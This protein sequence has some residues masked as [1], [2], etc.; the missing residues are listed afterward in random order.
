[1][2]TRYVECRRSLRRR[3]SAFLGKELEIAAYF[4]FRVEAL[5]ELRRRVSGNRY[6]PEGPACTRSTCLEP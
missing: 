6:N 5:V 1:M 4:P 3:A 2:V